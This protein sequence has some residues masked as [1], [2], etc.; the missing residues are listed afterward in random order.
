VVSLKSVGGAG[1]MPPLSAWG[2]VRAPLSVDRS[3]RDMGRWRR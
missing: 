2:A 1:D 3:Q